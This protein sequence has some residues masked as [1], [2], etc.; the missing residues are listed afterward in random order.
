MGLLHDLQLS[1]LATVLASQWKGTE[2]GS[3]RTEAAS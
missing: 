3:V 2:I 1:R